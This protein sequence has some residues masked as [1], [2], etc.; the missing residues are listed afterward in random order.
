[1]CIGSHGIGNEYLVKH[2]NSLHEINRM[3]ELTKNP[4][5]TNDS[6]KKFDPRKPLD[7]GLHPEYNPIGLVTLRLPGSAPSIFGRGTGWDNAVAESFFSSLKKEKIKKRIYK[8]REW[9]VQMCLITSRCLGCVQKADIVS[10]ICILHE[11]MKRLSKDDYK[12][13]AF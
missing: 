1:M 11:I 8:T 9:R 13:L 2:T 3:L 5:Y 7:R 10:M 4:K 12:F 6:L